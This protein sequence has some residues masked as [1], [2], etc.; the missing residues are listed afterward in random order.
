MSDWNK[1]YSNQ[2]IHG[3]G[4]QPTF[5]KG[6]VFFKGHG[7]FSNILG[8]VLKAATPMLKKTGKYAARQ[9]LNSLANF[10][11]EMLEGNSAKDAM[12]NTASRVLDHTKDD[13]SHIL[14]NKLRYNSRKRKKKPIKRTRQA[15]KK[16][17]LSG[18]L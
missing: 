15:K 10:S 12:R 1:Y 3:Y 6:N 4:A 17:K 11:N 14:K 7:V 9:G 13:L 5:V 8:S 18:Y 16:S 2:A